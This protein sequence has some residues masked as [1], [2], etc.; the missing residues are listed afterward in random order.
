MPNL[1][2]IARVFTVVPD[3]MLLV[4]AK[5]NI[6]I[7]N[8]QSYKLFGYDP[9]SLIGKSVAC[10]I[11]S[12]LGAAHAGHLQQ[13]FQAPSIRAMGIGME[14]SAVRA[15]GSEF[16]VEVSLSPFRTANDIYAFAAI[17]D[18]TER[19]LLSEAQVESLR[20]RAIA[21]ER[22]HAAAELQ[23][24]NDT[25][26]AI[27]DA[28][29][30]AI[31]TVTN[32]GIIDR[33]SRA[34]EEIYGYSAESVVGMN[35]SALD[36]MIGVDNNVDANAVFA[37][38]LQG[39]DLHDY[40]IKHRRK[41]GRVIEVSIDSASFLNSGSAHPGFVFLVDDISEHA[42]MEQ[43]LR[44]SQKMDA[45]GQLTGGIAH[46]FNN[47]LSIV[48]CNLELMI[49]KL[50]G[51][52]EDREIAVQALE[53]SLRG[54]ELIKQIMAFSRKQNLNPQAIA[55]NDLVRTMTNLLARTLGEHIEI[56]QETEDNI[57]PAVVDPVQLQTAIANLATNSRDAMPNGGKLVIQTKNTI[58]DENYVK[59][60]QDLKPGEYVLISVTDT[61]TGMSPEVAEKAFDPFF[62]TKRAG[63]GT[64]L[65]LSMVFG[66][67]KQS[68]GHIRIYSEPGVGTTIRLYLRRANVG[69][70]GKASKESAAQ[71]RSKH[72][73]KILMVEDNKDLAKSA[74]RLLTQAG[75][76][77][78]TAHTADAALEI[79]QK[80]AS[81]DLLFTD[82]ILTSGK[83][84][85]EL[86]TEATRILPSLK[87]LFASGFSE[88]AHRMTGRSIVGG[89]FISKPYQRD[90]LLHK[91][92]E[93]LGAARQ[94]NES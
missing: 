5:G 83:N 30:H 62:T 17:R 72:G 29:P 12:R 43:Q 68:G 86:A 2:S 88:A 34:A 3:A 56:V 4:D 76:V 84:G 50:P 40:R 60:F 48:I 82:I 8:E 61:G 94:I 1:E 21:E 18:I 66:F 28:S 19:K 63:E 7:A 14:L 64:G 10:L 77:V 35:L 24:R 93:V 38:I 91:I 36:R 87:T 11:P 25:L 33:W 47:L 70:E 49:E 16:A 53:A 23:S 52:S 74:Y 32:D 6:V 67:V 15:D 55:V 54:A 90:E 9:D 45:I 79:L 44:Q 20:Q 81:I 26:R 80:D 39:R 65:G 92:L 13:Y 58:L 78:I 42:A 71:P 85:I 59:Q 37:D 22:A 75:Y 57:W 27:F 73:A 69:T 51:G 31:I 41:D 89:R 46:D